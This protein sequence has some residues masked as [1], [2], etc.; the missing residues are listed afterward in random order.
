M[1]LKNNDLL[2]L[3]AAFLVGYFFHK[4]MKGCNL[5]EGIDLHQPYTTHAERQETD[6]TTVKLGDKHD[7]IDFIKHNPTG[8]TPT[9]DEYE[10][11]SEARCPGGC[12]HSVKKLLDKGKLTAKAKAATTGKEMC[13]LMNSDINVGDGGWDSN[14]NRICTKD[15]GYYCFKFGG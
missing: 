15:D 11:E 2:M 6:V 5:V 3:V 9:C 12:K 8:R 4:I 7:R 13:P 10:E 1:N 14:N